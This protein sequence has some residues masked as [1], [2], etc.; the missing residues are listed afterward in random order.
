MID[1][2]IIILFFFIKNNYKNN[3]L[4]KTFA[5][6]FYI[7]LLYDNRISIGF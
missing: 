3:Y 2:L 5:F 7:I 1:Y 4:L 6:A